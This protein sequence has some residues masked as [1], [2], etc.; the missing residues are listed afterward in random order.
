MDP[1][2]SDFYFGVTIGGGAGV[3]MA[4]LGGNRVS[5]GNFKGDMIP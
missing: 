4:D 3:F 2:V 1:L 5:L